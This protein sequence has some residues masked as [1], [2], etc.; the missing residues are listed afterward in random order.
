MMASIC[1][2]EDK[3]VGCSRW[4]WIE[5][6]IRVLGWAFHLALRVISTQLGYGSGIYCPILLF[7]FLSFFHRFVQRLGRKKLDFNTFPFLQAIQ[8]DPY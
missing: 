8:E 6:L 5:G 2:G 4:A 7:H 1:N 3:I